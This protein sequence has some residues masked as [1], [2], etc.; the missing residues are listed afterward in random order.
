VYPKAEIRDNVVD[1]VT[2]VRFEPPRDR[3]L[4]PE[5]TA[6][7]RIAVDRR[8]NVPESPGTTEREHKQRGRQ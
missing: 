6:T 5:M 3:T 7:V 8:E 2:V 4:R 1:Y